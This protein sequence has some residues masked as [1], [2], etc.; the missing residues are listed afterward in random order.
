MDNAN[1]LTG[2][3]LTEAID[4]ASDCLNRPA[5]AR[6]SEEQA[7]EYVRCYYP[8]G[9]AGFAQEAALFTYVDNV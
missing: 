9:A 2:E 7:I 5:T 4:W 8:G 3:L 6:V 1:I